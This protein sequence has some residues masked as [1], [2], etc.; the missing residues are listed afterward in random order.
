[1]YRRNAHPCRSRQ[2]TR[3]REE[4]RAGHAASWT[5]FR[6]ARQHATDEFMVRDVW[7]RW[8]GVH[9]PRQAVLSILCVR[10]R[11][12]R[13]GPLPAGL[14]QQ[15]ARGDTCMT[16]WPCSKSSHSSGHTSSMPL[17]T[18]PRAE[19]STLSRATI[20]QP[21]NV[22]QAG[23]TYSPKRTSDPNSI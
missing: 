4:R 15:P 18:R 5:I 21:C 14:D 13:Q 19:S 9:V 2:A 20:V 17:T 23:C 10:L 22:L 11:Q 3:P 1:M 6:H 8:W 12:S 7:M 16:E